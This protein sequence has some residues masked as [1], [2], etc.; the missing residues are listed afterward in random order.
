MKFNTIIVIALTFTL[1]FF[2]FYFLVAAMRVTI[3]KIR[4]ILT[5][6]LIGA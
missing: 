6:F 2:L 4:T 1:V 3:I 5:T